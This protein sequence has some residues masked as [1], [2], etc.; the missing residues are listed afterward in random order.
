MS[1]Q[2]VIQSLDEQI[3]KLQHARA[4]LNGRGKA[5]GKGR[6]PRTMT[7]AAR[8]RIAAAQ[9]ARWAGL[10]RQAKKK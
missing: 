8:A 4:L 1:I 3:A 10:K 5:T 7:A 2:Q 6:G 9:R